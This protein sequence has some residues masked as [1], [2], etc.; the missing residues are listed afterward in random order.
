MCPLFL[1]AHVQFIAKASASVYPEFQNDTLS[2]KRLRPPV[3]KA[4]G[5]TP[6]E[7]YLARLAEESFLNLWSYPSPFRNQHNGKEICD[8]LVVCGPYI[9][10]FSEKTVSW[11]NDDLNIAWSRWAKRAI[12]DAAKQ[13]AG[14]ERWITDYPDRIF[15]DRACKVPFPIDL[16][17]ASERI[18]HKI[19][20]ANGAAPACEQN[21]PECSGSL[22]I[23]PDI[24]GVAHW[25][26]D[27]KPIRP[28]CIGDINPS[29]SFVHVFNEPSLHI[30][31]KELDTITDFAEYLEKKASLVRS[32][33][34][35]QADG[36]ENLLA[37]YAIRVNE[38]G[39]HDFVPKGLPLKIDDTHYSRFASHPRYI[40]KKEADKISYLWDNLIESFTNHML[41][42]TSV[43]H[44][45]YE[46]Q[47]S[48]NERAVRFMALERRF[49]RRILG[50]AVK[51]ALEKDNQKDLNFRLM[52]KGEGTKDAKS[53]FFI[54]TFRYQGNSSETREYEQ[55]RKNRLSVAHIYAKCILVR[56]SFLKRVIGITCEPP[57]Q[58]HG[59]SEDMVYTEQASW[60]EEERN[61]IEE[62]CQRHG[63]FSSNMTGQQWSCQE[64]PEV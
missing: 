43:T 57:G 11:S 48:Q 42:G 60:T 22:I 40:K 62:Y 31:M 18:I 17:S 61:A 14:A 7:R 37:Y 2:M 51:G 29:D 50:E 39:E 47:L 45:K 16:P 10:I 35:I 53:A 21:I 30:V 12:R 64:Y 23:R 41:D 6:S 8:L 1:T 4:V 13:V 55:Y 24:K 15:L 63:I 36:E 34:L 58:P 3:T 20:V 56:Y 26:N 27:P 28:F 25:T 49:Y 44:G 33:R 9:I 46:F 59:A 54:L 52:I 5:V 32:G 19:V 38:N